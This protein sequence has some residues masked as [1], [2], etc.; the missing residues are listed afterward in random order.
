MTPP[1]TLEH[2]LVVNEDIKVEQSEENYADD[3]RLTSIIHDNKVELPFI[4]YKLNIICVSLDY[5]LIY[6]ISKIIFTL[7]FALEKQRCHAKERYPTMD[8]DR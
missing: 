7:N 5:F 1:W 8:F 6:G 3:S 2:T 4:I